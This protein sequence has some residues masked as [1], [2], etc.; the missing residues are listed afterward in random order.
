MA[1]TAVVRSAAKPEATP[2]GRRARIV[3]D[4]PIEIQGVRCVAEFEVNAGERAAFVYPTSMRISANRP[5]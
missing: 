3:S 5:R 1:A 4:V 2:K